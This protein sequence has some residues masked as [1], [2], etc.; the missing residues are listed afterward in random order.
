MSI[1]NVLKMSINARI[2][3]TVPI[4]RSIITAFS[5]NLSIAGVPDKTA[6]TR[7]D[8]TGSAAATLAATKTQT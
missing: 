3:R 8:A 1:P 6:A 7:T 4:E 5:L 2:S